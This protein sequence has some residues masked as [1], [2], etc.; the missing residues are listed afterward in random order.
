[1]RRCGVD[2]V[3]LQSFIFLPEVKVL[4]FM[5]LAVFCCSGELNLMTS[6]LKIKT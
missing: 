1:M 4:L 2:L 3:G 6:C 5:I